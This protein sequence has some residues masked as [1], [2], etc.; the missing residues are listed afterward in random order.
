MTVPTIEL[1]RD[2]AEVFERYPKLAQQRLAA[3]RALIFDIA[4]EESLG[5]VT[6]TLKWGE[7][8]YI[9]KSGTTVRLGWKDKDPDAVRVFVHCQ[10]RLI[11]TFREV[12]PQAF[13][14][15]GKRAMRLKLSG[16]IPKTP[17]KHCLRMALTYHQVKH[18]PLLGA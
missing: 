18:L 14:Y 1:A 12:Y 6:E 13:E 5:S 4:R 17:L 16:R 7:P 11:E 15:E 2:V 10:T 3:I 8:S 9:A